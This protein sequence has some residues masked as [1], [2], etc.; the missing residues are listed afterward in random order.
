M[1]AGRYNGTVT[2]KNRKRT[3]LPRLPPP[4]YAPWATKEDTPTKIADARQTIARLERK[5]ALRTNPS[6]GHHLE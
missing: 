2:A 1:I 5:A 6:S 4:P 3:N